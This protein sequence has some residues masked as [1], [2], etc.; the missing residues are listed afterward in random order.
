MGRCEVSSNFL[1]CKSPIC[2][3]I[4]MTKTRIEYIDILKGFG[5]ILVVL[6]HVTLNSDLYHFIY[7]FHMPLFFIVSGMFLHDRQGFIRKQAKNLLIPYLSFGLLTFVYWWLVESRFREL[8]AGETIWGQFINLLCP[9]GTQHCNVVLWF[10]PCLFL[11][12]VMANYL[13]R[14]IISRPIKISLVV[15]LICTVGFIHGNYPYHIGQAIQALPYICIG[16]LLG[17][18]I[19]ALINKI[20][21][22][23]RNK[24]IFF[25][26][27]LGIYIVY[28]SGVTCNMQS[29][30]F[31][32]CY[33]LSFIIALL[34]FISVYIIAFGIQKNRA[35]SWLGI[36][37]LAIMLMHEP[38][39]RIVIKVYSIIM[40]MPVDTI[41]ESVLQS[42]IITILTILILIPIILLT[43]KHFPFL[44]GKAKS[45]SNK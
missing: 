6:G 39:K 29:S 1:A 27:L 19:N 3:K 2:H 16:S 43:N 36:N 23:K 30:S 37:S 15:C 33:P 8:P 34:G 5:I 35:L 26:G 41:R 44:L 12:C 7:A 42:L 22:I 9:V 40:K 13:N 10:L 24:T 25:F 18:G 11:A 4:D 31:S 28:L 32:P 38:V 20:L 14:W 17:G 45:S 21:T